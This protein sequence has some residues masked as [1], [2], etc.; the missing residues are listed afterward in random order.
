MDAFIGEIR[1][2]PYY[3]INS[4]YGWCRCDGRQLLIRQYPA[5]HSI[6]GNIYGGDLKTYFN[7]PNIIGRAVM[8]TD[9]SIP[10]SDSGQ[11]GSTVGQRKNSI[12]LDNIP[13]HTHAVRA[14]RYTNSSY[15]DTPGSDTILS[16]PLNTQ[17]YSTP[18]SAGATS[19]LATKTI[20][21]S[22]FQPV[23]PIEINNMQPCLYINN[24]YIC[25]DGGI[26]PIKD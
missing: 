4:I 17:V 23:T 6:I 22:G 19:S 13:A 16:A 20:G 26:Y 2:L 18:S 1:L 12:K 11:I 10:L 8:G 5:L 24:Y 7:V 14:T 3:S 25:L 15:T 9:N 21:S